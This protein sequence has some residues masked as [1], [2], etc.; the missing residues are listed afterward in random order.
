VPTEE[1]HNASPTRLK[2]EDVETGKDYAVIMSTNAGL[3]A[4]NI[5][6]T[7]EFISKNPYRI[8]V[9][10]RIKHFISAFG[11]HVI[12]KEVEEALRLTI[13]KHPCLIN[14]FTVAPQVN[15]VEGQKPF[16][17]WWIEF[18]EK[19]KD[20]VSFSNELDRAMVEQNLYYRDLIEGKILQPLI[21]QQLPPGS[22]N[23][24][25]VFIDKGK[26]L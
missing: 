14:E 9:T 11:E 7:I 26:D 20:M 10:G 5:G 13:A 6:D 23:Q 2:L 4:Y 16:H 19:P 15:P 17:E 21:V 22:N 12:A 1:I 25:K 18:G 8:K 3:W 24:P